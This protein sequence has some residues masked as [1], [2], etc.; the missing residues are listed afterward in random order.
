MCSDRFAV[1]KLFHLR[2]VVI[3]KCF[4]ATDLGWG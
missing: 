1:L 2:P 3:D 4:M